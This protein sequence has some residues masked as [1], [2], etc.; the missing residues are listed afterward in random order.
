V[1]GNGAVKISLG[2]H[3]AHFLLGPDLSNTLLDW[4]NVNVGDFDALIVG[5]LQ[6]LSNNLRWSLDGQGLL[7][8]ALI[9]SLN[10]SSPDE[11]L[12]ILLRHVIIFFKKVPEIVSTS[13]ISKTHITGE[14]GL[15]KSFINLDWWHQLSLR[16]Q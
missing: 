1:L 5:N 16:Q 3:T 2:V 10:G 15:L 6:F 7:R 4:P 8:A 9:G 12:P 11:R 13:C 14:V